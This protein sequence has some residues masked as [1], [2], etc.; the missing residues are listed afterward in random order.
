MSLE[1]AFT[2]VATF[3]IF[4]L[5]SIVYFNDKKSVTN[6]LF[7]YISLATVFWALS[8][9]FS[10]FLTGHEVLIPIRLV[11]FFAAP[12]AVLFVLFVY[13]F[14]KTE[15]S[16]RRNYFWIAII[17][18]VVAMVSSLSPFVFT[19]VDFIDGKP[20]PKAGPLMP[21]FGS[22]ILG[23]L[24]IGIY[25]I[26]KKYKKADLELKRRWRAILLGVL[27]SYFL[28]IL[29]QFIFV[30]A[31]K[32]TSLVILAP[33]FMLPTFVGV[34]YATLRYR[35]LNPKALLVEILVFTLIIL[36]LFELLISVSLFQ[37][38]FRSILF[39]SLFI[40][41][42]FLVKGVLNE[43]E[44][45]EKIKI[46][47]HNLEIANKRQTNLIHFITHQIKGFFTKSKYIF[48]ELLE[49]SYGELTPEIKNIVQEGLKFNSEGVEVVQDILHASNIKSGKVS[50]EMKP[51]DFKSLVESVVEIERKNA[52][53]KKLNFVFNVMD[54]I[55]SINGDATNLKHAIRNII[56]NSIKYTP[57]GKV[58]VSL[59][60]KN[61]K[62]LLLIKDTGVGL[63]E[64]DKKHLFTEG[65]KGEN[66]NKI[67]VDSTGYGLFI[68]KGII[69]AH[70][71]KIWA[72]SEGTGKGATFVIE[73][74]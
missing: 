53:L 33:L 40:V 69:E 49:G 64:K 39:T 20:I 13:N 2:L 12:H 19:D 32:N 46:L 17:I 61:N 7:F 24:I 66:S 11:L 6:I 36:T 44:Q 34:T 41:G 23:S 30:V 15:L 60:K 31:F 35:L 9:F 52:E 4:F 45:K 25:F 63:S 14:P 27:T 28:L 42:I 5:G 55:Y 73:L 72:E 71:G 59:Q 1:L 54:S 16:I 68:V 10:L 26:F 18:M 48:A 62:I 67:N 58:E 74:G 50:Y 57:S 47:A 8:N 70:G 38:I 21:L 51:L 43:V 22:V 65:G 56:D 3:A 37:I 29:T